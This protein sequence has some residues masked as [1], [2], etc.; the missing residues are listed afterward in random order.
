MNKETNNF[1]GENFK[2]WN[3]AKL[4]WLDSDLLLSNYRRNAELINTTQQIVAETT[5]AV[6][7]LQAQYMKEVFEQA[8]TQT[9]QNMTMGSPE[10]KVSRQS[11]AT[12]RNLDQAVEHTRNLNDILSQSNEKIIENVQKRF[13]ETIDETA[14]MAKKTKTKN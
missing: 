10:E 2:K 8:N 12:K 6:I 11:D 9:K 4:P 3:E 1:W 5:K 13:K 14:S 7:Q